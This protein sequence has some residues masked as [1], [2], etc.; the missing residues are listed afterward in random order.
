MVRIK[1]MSSSEEDVAIVYP[2]HRPEVV[3]EDIVRRDRSR[4][5]QG[6][7][8]CCMIVIILYMLWWYEYLFHIDE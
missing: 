5:C 7:A 3:E 4:N 8:T 1:Y 6:V 2:I